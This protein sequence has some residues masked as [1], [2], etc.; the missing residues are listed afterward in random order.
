VVNTTTG[1]LYLVDTQS[2]VANEIDLGGGSLVGGDGLLLVGNTLYVVQGGLNQIAVVRSSDG[3]A[4][5]VIDRVIADPAFRFPSTVAA[6]G[7]SLYV[8][9]ARFD[10]TG[11]P[12]VEFDVVRVSR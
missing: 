7:S 2:G 4:R 12:D 11:Y 3:Y 6:F 5:G 1:K 10:A 8:V 9:N